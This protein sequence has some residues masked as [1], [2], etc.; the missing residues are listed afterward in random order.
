MQL[1]HY[2]RINTI[3][4]FYCNIRIVRCIKNRK[5]SI[6]FHCQ[7]IKFYYRYTSSYERL[8][9]SMTINTAPLWR[10]YKFIR[11]KRFKIV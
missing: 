7:I 5:A 3:Q 11:R 8:I 6:F 10:N 4:S 9:M 2:N 1:I